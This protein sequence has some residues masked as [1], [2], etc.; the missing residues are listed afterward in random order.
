MKVL[1]APAEGKAQLAHI[2]ANAGMH[3]EAIKLLDMLKELPK[4]EYLSPYNI[5]LIYAGLGDRE[6]AFEWLK[7]ASEDHSEW[8]AS[9]RVDPRLDSLREDARFTDL[10]RKL[11]FAP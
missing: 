10:L 2:Y 3:E 9:L 8:F 5:A 6:Q 4:T 7:K 1:G 11:K